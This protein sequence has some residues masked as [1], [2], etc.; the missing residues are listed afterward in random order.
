[1][2]Y[3]IYKYARN[4]SWQCLIDCQTFQLPIKVV[5]I[6]ACYDIVCRK[7]NKL[8]LCSAAG[9]IRK[10]NGEICIFT[11]ESQ[12]AERRRFTIMHELGH[13]L[14]GHLGDMPLSRSEH[15]CNS[16]EE[17]AADKFAADVLMPACVLWG[18][19]IQTPEE[20]AKLCNVSMQAATIRAERM[21][22]LY[23]RNK[24]LLH[25]LERQVYVQFSEFIQNHKH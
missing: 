18:L 6:A 14:L 2:N 19:N 11:D 7:S 15:D 24:F 23:Q 12:T 3:G 5:Q 25:P 4:S 16:E 9:E 10:E 20:I 8:D 13:Y 17:Q 22:V 21:K 1:M